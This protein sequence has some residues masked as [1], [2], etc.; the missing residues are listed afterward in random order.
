MTHS[1]R[2]SQPLAIQ[3]TAIPLVE[4]DQPVRVTRGLKDQ[5]R[6][7]TDEALGKVHIYLRSGTAVPGAGPSATYR[8]DA[9]RTPYARNDISS[10][11]CHFWAL[12]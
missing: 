3:V 2:P 11:K 1:D 7:L 9:Q 12:V 10:E 6:K 4:P 8:G 5:I